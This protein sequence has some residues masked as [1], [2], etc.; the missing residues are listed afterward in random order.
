MVRL[1]LCGDVMP[2]RGVDQ[3]LPHAGDPRLYEPV[4]TSA[5][6]YVRLAEAASGPIPRPV[7]PSYVWGDALAELARRAPD[8]RIVNLETAVTAS[9]EP[10]PR[11]GIHYRM[12]PDNVGCLVAAKLDCCVLANNHVLDWGRPGLRETLATLRSA[13]IATAGAG[14]DLAEASAPALIDR[15]A[16]GRVA[17]FA[18]GSTTSG[19]PKPWA[20]A[21]DRPGVRLLPDLSDATVD[22][23]AAGVRAVKRPG[24]LVLASIHWGDNWG[25][26][27]PAGQRRFARRLIDGAGVDLVHG[28]S[29]HHPK[30][31]EV[32]RGHLILYGCGDLLDDYEGIEGDEAFRGE[33]R[34]LYFAKLDPSTG[35][36]RRLTMTP[37]RLRRFRIQRASLDEAR[38]LGAMLTREGRAFGTR[39]RVIED[40]T[41]TLE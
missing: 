13:G 16:A 24:T 9:G 41:L 39:A 20:A 26:D 23:V 28:H 10:W 2:G 17:V 30:A 34:L 40:G 18:F 5:L 12:H 19:I 32:H 36:L 21:A 3:V 31:I 33:L 37:V 29:S 1:F 6:E 15:G 11:K 14:G 22:E 38:W 27:I 35:A 8:V 4:V 25:Y 7:A